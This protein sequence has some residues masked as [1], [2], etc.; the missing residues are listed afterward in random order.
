MLYVECDML[1][2]YWRLV[3]VDGLVMLTAKV[4]FVVKVVFVCSM[5]Y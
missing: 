5:C 4:L 1:G 2:C 3:P